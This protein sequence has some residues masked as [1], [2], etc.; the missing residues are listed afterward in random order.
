VKVGSAVGKNEGFGVGNTLGIGV[1]SAVGI[2]LGCLVGIGVG[3]VVGRKVGFTVG[4]AVGKGWQEQLPSVEVSPA[5]QV[6]H[7][8]LLEE[9]VDV[10][11]YVP[12]T[13]KAQVDL[14]TYE[15]Q[16]QD[17]VG[18]ADGSKVGSAVGNF[19]GLKVGSGVGTY[20]GSNVGSG[21]GSAVGIAMQL[22]PLSSGVYPGGQSTQLEAPTLLT[23]GLYVSAGQVM[24]LSFSLSR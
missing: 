1:G 6:R 2:A 8:A 20:V 5:G 11:L 9:V 21:V 22:H 3:G 18:N 24:Q 17:T 23:A 7:T 16:P 4:L 12:A 14:C 13:H 10:A 19:D 15:P